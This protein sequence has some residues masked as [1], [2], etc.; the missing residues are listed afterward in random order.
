MS[1]MFNSQVNTLAQEGI[2]GNTTIELRVTKTSR[3][4]DEVLRAERGWRHVLFSTS[5]GRVTAQKDGSRVFANLR[6]SRRGKSGESPLHAQLV[7]VTESGITYKN[8]DLQ[9]FLIA[10]QGIGNVEFKFTLTDSQRDIVQDVIEEDNLSMVVR[11]DYTQ[12]SL[13]E[14][15]EDF[16]DGEAVR[17][18]YLRP[19]YVGFVE[20]ATLSDNSERRVDP[21]HLAAAMDYAMAAPKPKYR[22]AAL[23][24][25]EAMKVAKVGTGKKAHF[26]L[27]AR[28]ASS[29][30]YSKEWNEAQSILMMVAIRGK[31]PKVTVESVNHWVE[32]SLNGDLEAPKLPKR[33]SST[34]EVVKTEPEMVESEP[35][36]VAEEP[37]EGTL[38]SGKGLDDLFM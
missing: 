20:G 27:K 31:N 32:E 2:V 6:A 14:V 3:Q 30:P 38:A 7:Q 33:H 25:A 16:S 24:E 1:S 13:C 5:H 8:F 19:T 17:V 26:E 37:Q 11:F 4:R 28:L 9:K 35:E 21:A 12:M 34:T 10:S 22:D 36:V 23:L 29:A 15:T 18:I